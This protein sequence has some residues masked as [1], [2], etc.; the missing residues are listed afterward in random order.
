VPPRATTET[1]LRL[2]RAE[3][4]EAMRGLA[5]ARAAVD[6]AETARAAA[7]AAWDALQ[8]RLRESAVG[9]G[10]GRRRV[11]RVGE[12]AAREAFAGELRAQLGA[13]Q[14][15]R[16]ALE[17]QVRQALQGVT[18]AQQRV[19]QALRAREAAGLQREAE[20]KAGVRRRERRDQAAADDR[21]RPPRK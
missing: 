4:L 18:A 12:L 21:W 16:E 2:R 13:V 5:E 20:E 8:A 17:R 9:D 3:E 10:R 15:R 1:L 11:R 14:A 7:V 19:E 6:R